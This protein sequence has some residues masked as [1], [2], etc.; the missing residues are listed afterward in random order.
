MPTRRATLLTA[1]FLLASWRARTQS[2]WPSRP[3][4]ILVPYGTGGSTDVAARLLADRLSQ[5]LPQRAVVENRTGAGGNLAAAA[6]AKGPGDGSV[7]LFTNVGQ[8]AAKA[9][10][11]K[12]D[13]DPE[14]ELRAVTTVTEG[15]MA[16]LVPPG[17]PYRTIQELLDAA[18]R[19]PG[20][21]TY[22]SSGGGGALQLVSLQ[23]LRAA[24]VQMTE[25]AYRGSGQAPLDLAS[26]SLD[27]LFD[28][29]IAGFAAVRADRARILA[30]SSA[31][32]S[33][34]MPE[35]PTVAE[36]GLPGATFSIWQMLMAPATTP[37]AIMVRIHAAVTE[38]LADAV[39]R[40]RL[41]DLGAERIPGN[42]QAE[43]QRHYLAEV[44][45]WGGLLRGATEA[46]R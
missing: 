26:G 25:V 2:E 43:A 23:F 15:P 6:V 1:P 42:P 28:S 8:A 24:G 12:L 19:Q 33:T 18:R 10:F 35:V 32:R 30:V 4:R 27:M 40:Q 34:V 13:Y 3:I 21:L 46:P 17:S 16:L 39:L 20:R 11:P 9:L 5:L 22:G 31:Q 36:A 37:D 14:T 44:A 29:G 7:L 38:A 45:R 41:T